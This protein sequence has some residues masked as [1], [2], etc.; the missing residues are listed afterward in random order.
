MG[1]TPF[2]KGMRCRCPRC[3][4]GALYDGLLDVRERCE[5]CGFDLTECDAGDGAQVFV[6]LILGAICVV[7]GF[8]LFGVLELPRWL[9]MGILMVTTVVAALWMLRI[10]KAIFIALQFHH[11]AGEGRLVEDDD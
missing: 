11:D 2:K 10:F 4:D 3:G 9:A 1:D 5:T 7:L 6:I 8:Y